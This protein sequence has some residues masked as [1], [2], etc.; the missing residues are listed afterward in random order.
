VAVAERSRSE[1]RSL[2]TT[3]GRISEVEQ[4]A[5]FLG[6]AARAGIGGDR[7]VRRQGQSR[8]RAE[9]GVDGR[10]LTKWRRGSDTATRQGSGGGR[11]KQRSAAAMGVCLA[12][13]GLSIRGCTRRARA[14][15]GH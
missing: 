4:Q 1:G 3:A 15:A 5:S 12:Q 11:Q 7:P 10:Q 2:Q 14:L 8:R 13:S 6:G 9:A